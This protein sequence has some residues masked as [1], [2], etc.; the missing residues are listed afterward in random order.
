MR[1]LVDQREELARSICDVIFPTAP[2]LRGADL[3]TTA[4]TATPAAVSAG[5]P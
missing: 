1:R 4:T 5:T 2:R 3:R